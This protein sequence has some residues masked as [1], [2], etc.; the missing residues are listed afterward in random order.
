MITL[1]PD[2]TEEEAIYWKNIEEI[3][4]Y[5]KIIK[6]YDKLLLIKIKS[7][8]EGQ[9]NS[10]EFQVYL[11]LEKIS[12]IENI[13]S[14]DSAGKDIKNRIGNI[15][16]E[17]TFFKD[18]LE[19]SEV[20]IVEEAII[21][22]LSITAQYCC[23][24]FTLKIILD[25]IYLELNENNSKAANISK[26]TKEEEEEEEVSSKKTNEKVIF[27]KPNGEKYKAFQIAFYAF[28][29][30]L[31][32]KDPKYDKHNT[33]KN[34][35]INFDLDNKTSAERIYNEFYRPITKSFEEENKPDK[36]FEALSLK[37]NISCKTI[38]KYIEEIMPLLNS[39]GQNEAKNHIVSL[40]LLIN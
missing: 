31:K 29:Q 10:R 21:Y 25:L 37:K 9:I 34:L 4:D 36:I 38:K 35:A 11:Y 33:L 26:I 15:K 27:L 18:Y 30:D 17:G 14:W 6:H 22:L 7:F 24:Y 13:N 39:E 5:K 23:N 3:L 28:Y 2:F 32:V 8:I 1:L 40:D 20:K 16:L 12:N 19:A